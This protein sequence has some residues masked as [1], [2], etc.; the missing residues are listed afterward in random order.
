LQQFTATISGDGNTI[1]G[2][3]ALL[4]LLIIAAAGGGV[5]MFF[6]SGMHICVNTRAL[7]DPIKLKGL[8]LVGMWFTFIVFA[9]PSTY[10]LYNQT[11]T[12][13]FGG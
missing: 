6:Y 3:E 1:A 13:V 5:V 10:L 12:N 11:M 4:V 2:L 9:I 7:P 8:R